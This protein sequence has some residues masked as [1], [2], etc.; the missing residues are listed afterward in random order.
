MSGGLLAPPAPAGTRSAGSSQPMKLEAESAPPKG[1]GV[2]GKGV[3]TASA[4]QG[5]L[6]QG[7]PQ[8]Q[9]GN[10][11]QLL[12]KMCLQSAQLVRSL[13]SAVDQTYICS[14][15]SKPIVAETSASVK[16]NDEVGRAGRGHRLGRLDAHVVAA[17]LVQ[18]L[19]RV[20]SHAVGPQHRILRKLGQIIASAF[21]P[22]EVAAASHFQLKDIAAQP[23]DEHRKRS[24][25][26]SFAVTN[27]FVLADS[28]LMSAHLAQA[29]SWLPRDRGDHLIGAAL[30]GPMERAAEQRLGPGRL[31]QPAKR[32]LARGAR[33]M[34][35]GPTDPKVACEDGATAQRC[36]G[37]GRG[38]ALAREP[39]PLAPSTGASSALARLASVARLPLWD[40]FGRT[41]ARLHHH[42]AQE[43]PGV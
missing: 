7:V 39:C 20:D 6:G 12:T 27:D 40:R 14:A 18:A 10:P 13:N 9:D 26:F 23:E 16:Y 43:P 25:I 21:T 2:L 34:G 42:R 8:A 5:V 24:V 11:V 38:L 35:G 37:G 1:H 41:E 30:K 33:G 28:D 36:R 29:M 32:K 3:P 17:F 22:D 4:G 19:R 31:R 15:D